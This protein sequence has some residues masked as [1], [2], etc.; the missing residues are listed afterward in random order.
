MRDEKI[1]VGLQYASTLQCDKFNL[2]AELR[3]R[4]V[5]VTAESRNPALGGKLKM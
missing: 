1:A 4:G 3:D 2:D 5:T